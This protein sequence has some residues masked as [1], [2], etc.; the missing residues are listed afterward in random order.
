MTKNGRN[1]GIAFSGQYLNALKASTHPH[2]A[3][4][5]KLS[6]NPK[7]VIFNQEMFES[8]LAYTYMN[9]YTYTHTHTHRERQAQAFIHSLGSVNS[10]ILSSVC[11]CLTGNR[12]KKN[13]A[14]AN[15]PYQ[16]RL[17]IYLFLY[18]ASGS[19]QFLML[20]SKGG[21][22]AGNQTK[23]TLSSNML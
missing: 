11:P 7:K 21:G 23:R 3:H 8:C 18:V 1:V 5:T 13:T 9:A 20:H 16:I 22:G 15:L 19:D 10:S 4:F 17:H 12:E 2:L 6:K 14:T